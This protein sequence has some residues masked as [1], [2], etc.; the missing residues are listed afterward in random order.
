MSK[1][2][3]H[4]QA[5]LDRLIDEKLPADEI[6]FMMRLS[7]STVE[8]AIRARELNTTHVPVGGSR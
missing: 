2:P 5:Q 1:L 7:E 3:E 8:E 6:A 4:I